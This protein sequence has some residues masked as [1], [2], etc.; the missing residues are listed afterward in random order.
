MRFD[1]LQIPAFGPFTQFELQFSNSK[2]D[3]HVIYGANEAGKS[4]LL[5]AIHNLLYGIPARS[6][7]N[8]LHAYSKLLIGAKVSDGKDELSF[9]RKKGNQS[10]LLDPNQNSIDE[11]K[12]KAFCGSVNDE[13]FTHMFGLS[14]DSLR[15]GAE[16]LLSGEGELGTLLFSASLG[17]SP[18]DTAL[19]RLQ[20]EADQLF[21]G[22][23]RKANAIVIAN[24]AFKE[25]EKESRDLST[26]AHA[27]SVLQKSIQEAEVA[28]NDKEDTLTGTR[29]R[30]HHLKNLIQAIPL[31]S[32]LKQVDAQLKEIT[33]PQLP[34]DF[35]ERVRNAQG[36]LSN[37]RTRCN[38]DALLLKR[39]QKQR[40]AIPAYEE[41][42]EDASDLDSLHQG[43]ASHLE[44]IGTDSEK[45][46]TVRQL[47][48]QLEDQL[49]SIGL[50]SAEALTSLPDLKAG[51]LA[52]LDELSNLISSKE[53]ILEQAQANLGQT[54]EELAEA[55]DRIENL[56]EAEVTPTIRDLASRIEEHAQDFKVA[57]TQIDNHKNLTAELLESVRQLG[58]VGFD[59]EEI[60]ELPVPALALLEELHLER[61]AL[62]EKREAAQERRDGLDEKI[63]EKKA[64]IEQTSGNIAVHADADL[65]RVREQRD[66]QWTALAAQLKDGTAAAETEVEAFTENIQKSDE[67]ADA[68][69]NHAEILG[70]LATLNHDYDLL[71]AQRDR[72]VQI[73]ERLDGELAEWGERWK[74]KSQVLPDRDFLPAELIEWRSQWETW[75]DIS[76][77][78]TTLDEKIAA[79]RQIEA[80]LLEELRQHFESPEAS[81]GV[82]SRQLTDAIE[83]ANT[84]KGE[85]KGLN[86]R[87]ATLTKKKARQE[88]ALTEASEALQEAQKKWNQAL[89]EHQ[90]DDPGSTKAALASLHARHDARET[91]QKIEDASEH[92]KTLA[93]QIAKFQKRLVNQRDKHLPDS[94]ELDPKNPDLT[95]ARLWKVLE[96]A[97]QNQTKHNS[98][99]EEIED[100]ETELQ[101]KQGIIT[102]ADKEIKILVDE[103][104]IVS[105]DELSAA[106]TQFEKRKELTAQRETAHRTLVN[107]A[108]SAPVE[109]LIAEAEASERN[110]LQAE[111]DQLAPKIET[112]QQE[113][114][115]ARDLLNKELEKRAELEKAKGGAIDAKQRA[116]NALAEIVTDSE[117]FIRL[118]HAIAFLKA[119]VEAYR[120]K[121]QGPMIEKT[122]RFFATLTNGSF[123]GVAAQA[124]ENDPNRVNLVALSQRTDDPNGAAETL[125]TTALSEGTRDQLYLAL[126]LAAIDIH[127]ENHAPMPLILDDI[128]I[129]FDDERAESV[130]RVLKILSE[131]TQVLVF[132]HHQHIAKLAATF[133]PENHLLNLP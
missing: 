131:K 23:G 9:L 66:T 63:I 71:T 132:T 28:F 88:T 40:D 5:R 7:D 29:Q 32:E 4:S 122:G 21:A 109:S 49:N 70:R 34:S 53:G 43:T 45:A 117:R 13:F 11:G 85:R 103:A 24:K 74:E 79:H 120:E 37:A 108:G 47:S 86:E 17:G 68:L 62:L 41:I 111:L 42:V 129:T 16:K 2:E 52:A 106:I 128:L 72:E 10:T 84:A 54:T 80:D 73:I 97:R 104:K 133:V 57:A 98:L 112:L 91:Y 87:I 19:E 39:K 94:P 77:R 44:A 113:R 90:L 69:R 12:L 55:Q 6:N 121:S 59:A 15:D 130:F 31:V 22:N 119:Q 20:G 105:A 114:D 75:C 99:I 126:R 61:K 3:L 8:F 46:E 81:Y 76:S 89:E 14:T 92:L 124:D 118:H 56:G 64:D 65:V 101:A 102:A 96:E 38:A 50:D 110:Q 1:S 58:L 48:Q 33:L 83:A 123:L 93:D 26:T 36:E 100:L 67:I 51:D 25:F 60:R 115:E 116:A 78:L 125:N 82:L 18:I 30:A 95:E 127:L 27:W 107:L 35:A